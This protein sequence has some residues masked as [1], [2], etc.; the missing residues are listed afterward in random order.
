M[1]E[2]AFSQALA[3]ES[4]PDELKEL[5]IPSDILVKYAKTVSY[6][7][8]HNLKFGR[9]MNPEEDPL[10]IGDEPASKAWAHHYS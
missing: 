6:K 8:F 1:K 7:V 10:T 2:Q 9:M 4:I 3:L 5:N